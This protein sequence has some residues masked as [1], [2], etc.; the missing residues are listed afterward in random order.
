MAG[1][2]WKWLEMACKG[3]KWVENHWIWLDMAGNDWKWLV[4][5]GNS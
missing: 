3:Y 1:N 2:A 5:D 4:M